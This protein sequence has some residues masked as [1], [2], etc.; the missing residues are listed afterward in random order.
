MNAFARTALFAAAA[1]ALAAPL[2]AETMGG[3]KL[4]ATL[5]GT[6]EVPG[7][8]DPNGTGS[9]MARVNPGTGQFCYTL[10]VTNIDP[11]TM[12]H[13]HKGPAGAAGPVVIALTAPA[14]G[15]SEA[16][17]TITRELAMDLIMMPG[18]YYAN[19][20]NAAYPGGAVRGQLGK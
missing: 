16:C 14:S 6:A 7:P 11:A 4:S 8:G 2:A 10:T 15:S 17:V 5:S 18:D 1:A 12:A 13:I 3:R 20:H 9:I 19:V